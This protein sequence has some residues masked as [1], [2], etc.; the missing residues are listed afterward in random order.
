[1]LKN[2]RLP[3]RTLRQASFLLVFLICEEVLSSVWITASALAS[4]SWPPFFAMSLFVAASA[5][6]V[7]AIY[8]LQIAQSTAQRIY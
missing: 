7:V 3:P 8:C 1:M 4:S 5:V 6:A 2:I